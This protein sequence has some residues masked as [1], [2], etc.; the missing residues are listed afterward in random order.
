MGDTSMNYQF[1]RRLD[2]APESF[3]D[4]LFAVSRDPEIIS[5][6]GGLPITSLIDVAGI[7]DAA[8]AVFADEGEAALQYTTTD[9][10]LPCGNILRGGAIV[11]V[12]AFPPLQMRYASRTAPSSAWI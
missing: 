8:A 1:A 6:A 2:A 5:F 4:R 10:Y 9:G 11:P 3:L 12:W 7:R